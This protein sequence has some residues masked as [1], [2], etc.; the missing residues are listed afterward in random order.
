MSYAVILE[1]RKKKIGGFMHVVHALLTL[2]TLIWGLVWVGHYLYVDSHNKK[3]EDQINK[4]MRAQEK[5]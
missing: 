2:T 5:L 4:L 3:L 1:M